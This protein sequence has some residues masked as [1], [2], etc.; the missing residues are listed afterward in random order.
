MVVALSSGRLR[1][2][3]LARLSLREAQLRLTPALG[4]TTEPD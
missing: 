4:Q 2:E 1:R 3:E